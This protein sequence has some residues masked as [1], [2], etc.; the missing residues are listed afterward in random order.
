MDTNVL[1]DVTVLIVCTS[2]KT[3]RPMPRRRIQWVGVC[4]KNNCIHPIVWNALPNGVGREKGIV[5]QVC[6]KEY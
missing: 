3:T 2:K 4:Y 1:M 6:F 5:K